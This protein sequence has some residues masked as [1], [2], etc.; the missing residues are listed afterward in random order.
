MTNM[1]R[2]VL[3]LAFIFAV[4]LGILLA[5]TLLGNHGGS[6]TSTLPPTAPPSA[7]APPSSSAAA[8]A[9]GAPS[10]S[11]APS[12]SPSPTPT[13]PPGPAATIAFVQLALDAGTDPGGTTR[14]I[15]FTAQNGPVSVTPKPESGGNTVACLLA[16]GKQ[17]SCR[18]GVSGTLTASSAS[19]SV[20]YQVTLR[21]SGAAT[22]VVDVAVT[23]P[24]TKPKVTVTNARFDGTSNPAYNGLQVVATPRAKGYYHVTANWG[25]HPFLY[26]V[27]LIEQGGPGLKTIQA[28]TGSTN[29]SQGFAVAPPNPWMIVLKN[30][31]SGFGITGLTAAFTWP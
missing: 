31:E 28:A 26:E 23:F 19:A 22:P 8:S 12:A 9:S 18:T 27:D 20:S 14:T 17:L 2:L 16:S 6:S 7:S 3:V 29:V 30:S 11:T 25:G 15:A 1:Q 13:P 21:G 10:A 5:T 4:L 24:A